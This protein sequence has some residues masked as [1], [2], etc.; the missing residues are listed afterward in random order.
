MAEGTEETARNTSLYYPAF[1]YMFEAVDMSA[2]FWQPPLKAMGRAQLELA[3]LQARQTR[4]LVQWAYQWMRP[5]GPADIFNANAQLWSTIMQ[6]FAETAPRVAAAVETATEA[7]A[8]P[9]V[10]HMPAKPARDTLILIDRD[11]ADSVER[12]V[13]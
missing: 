9:A 10:L 12:K 13:A 11:D 7:A 8:R 4:A 1:Q 6:E 3:N 5:I 2:S